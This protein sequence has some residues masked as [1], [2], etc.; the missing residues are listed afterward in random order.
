MSLADDIKTLLN[1]DA[2]LLAI[3]TGGVHVGVMEINKQDTPSA[4]D[5]TK[6]EIKPCALIKLGVE[7]KLADTRR[8]VQTPVT[9]YVYE[10]NGYSSINAAMVKIFDHLNEAKIGTRTWNIRH[11]NT[12]YDQRDIA[13]DCSLATLRFVAA[14]NL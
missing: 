3:L 11:S 9:I 8:G 6:K 10:R 13:L 1:A 12:V 2:T 14:R 4:Y 5:A 7:N